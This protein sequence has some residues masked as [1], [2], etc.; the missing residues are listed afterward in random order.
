VKRV[1]QFKGLL[2]SAVAL[3]AAGLLLALTP[4]AQAA[5]NYWDSDGNSSG[6]NTNGTNLGGTGT[7]DTS[8]KWWTNGAAADFAWTSG[9]IAYFLGGTT[10]TVTLNS[11]VTAGGLIFATT[12]YTLSGTG[13]LTLNGTAFVQVNSGLSATIAL[14]L[15]GTAGL[16]KTGTGILTLSG[17]NLVTGGITINA[18]TVADG[19]SA[20]VSAVAMGNN[21][22]TIGASAVLDLT[23]V[24][25]DNYIREFS[26]SGQIKA[27][28]QSDVI[29]NSLNDT[30]FSG[31]DYYS[32]TSPSWGMAKTGPGTL[33]FTGDTI[34]LNLQTGS[35]GDGAKFWRGGVTFGGTLGVLSWRNTNPHI[36]IYN[37]TVT[38][39][40]SAANIDRVS[41]TMNV[42]VNGGGGTFS[43]IGG[44]NTASDETLGILNITTSV[45]A[46]PKGS[47]LNLVVTP[48]SGSG[49]AALTFSS[50]SNPMGANVQDGAGIL[51]VI[52]TGTLGTSAKVLFTTAPTL[53]SNVMAGAFVNGTDIATYDATFG[54]LPFQPTNYVGSLPKYV[55]A[56]SAGATDTA[57]ASGNYTLGADTKWNALKIDGP[58]TIDLSG[59]T[60]T[61]GQTGVGAAGLG[62]MVVKTGTGDA[63]IKNSSATVKY[64]TANG[65]SA[66]QVGSYAF[67]VNEGVLKVTA[68][69]IGG[70]LNNTFV[71]RVNKAGSGVLW[72]DPSQAWANNTADATYSGI[73]FSEGVIRLNP[74]NVNFGN[75]P[76][77]LNG[78]VME[79]TGGGTYAPTIGTGVSNLLWKTS[80]GFAAY[81]ANAEFSPSITWNATSHIPDGAALLLN[82]TTADSKITLSGTLN[83]GTDPAKMYLREIYVADNTN[84]S[85][86]YA[87]ISG[88]II[89]DTTAGGGGTPTYTYHLVKTGAGTLSL[90][91]TNNNYSGATYVKEGTLLVNGT[92]LAPTSSVVASYP[93]YSAVTVMNGA[94]LGG[95]GTVNRAVILDSG[96]TIAPGGSPGL[97]T[98]NGNL[99]LAAGRG[100]LQ[101]L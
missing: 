49:T 6:N 94:K 37:G 63:E 99:T 2:L 85:T 96:A 88:Q 95:T 34:Q 75:E 36:N 56:A 29:V 59:K 81:G 26:G 5:T 101:D 23:A 91:N 50:Y 4:R 40:E 60:L 17:V 14:T 19:G 54:V 22:I 9:D 74:R 80:G 42:V 57:Y 45:A 76:M 78:G 79:I 77:V 41:N 10:P 39:D 52:T 28:Y 83:L 33:T 73:Y 44:A 89:S 1:P 55:A 86:D 67:M 3:A 11:S 7:W 68:P 21:A 84:S 82:S 43:Y 24:A 61:L 18:G 46:A 58:V 97:F 30:T 70:S 65:G 53:V 13:V 31:T 35:A 64:F 47:S 98:V 27:N 16:T 20:A 66:G 93:N 12:G 15:A 87:E 72:L 92:L 48:G 90:A 38:I 100:A 71:L 62:A 25:G 8:N 51:N 32:T 69:L